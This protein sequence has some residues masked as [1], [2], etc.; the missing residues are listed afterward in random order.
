MSGGN[1]Q[2]APTPDPVLA[3]TRD[4]MRAL[5]SDTRLDLM[6]LF[7]TGD[8]LTVGEVTE[9]SGLAPSTTSEQLAILRRG[10]L[11]TSRRDGKQVRYRADRERIV[12]ALGDLTA[13]LQRCC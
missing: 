13:F 3:A 2:D 11:L 6:M 9:R 5:A 8:E 12:E 7:A 1:E 4:F 10:G